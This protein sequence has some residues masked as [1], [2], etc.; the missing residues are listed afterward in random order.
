MP[1]ALA[2]FPKGFHLI[3][4]ALALTEQS[5]V[6]IENIGMRDGG[7]IGAFQWITDET[8]GNA[9]MGKEQADKRQAGMG[10]QGFNGL[11]RLKRAG[12]MLHLRGECVEIEKTKTFL[13]FTPS[14]LQLL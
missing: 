4:I 12:F 5:Q 1:R 7:R 2:V 10:G 14:D 3:E 8:F 9:C 13:Y 6:G 11:I